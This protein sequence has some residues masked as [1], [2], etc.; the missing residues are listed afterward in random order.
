MG[1]F[2]CLFGTFLICLG[3]DGGESKDFE[4]TLIGVFIGL[5]NSIFTATV[6]MSSKV[7]IG[8]YNSY[9]LNV[10]L[11]FYASIVSFILAMVN[12]QTII[13]SFNFKL[14]VLFL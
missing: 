4:Y 3:E 1:C 13:Y 7:L 11:G 6:I 5:C 12:Y 9:E 14:I 10:M 2:V 8:I